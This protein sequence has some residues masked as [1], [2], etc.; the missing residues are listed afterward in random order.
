MTTHRM[1]RACEVATILAER[2]VPQRE[3][4]RLRALRARWSAE[5]DADVWVGLRRG[6]FDGGTVP[7]SVLAAP[8]GQ[9]QF[10]MLRHTVLA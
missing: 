6:E 3:G 2:D 1:R 9:C 10:R 7:A 4:V 5:R 8:F